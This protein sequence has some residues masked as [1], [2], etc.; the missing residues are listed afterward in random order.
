M[1]IRMC[2]IYTFA[3]IIINKKLLQLEVDTKFQ[4]M[5]NTENFPLLRYMTVRI[6]GVVKG[7][8]IVVA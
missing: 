3:N 8:I 4:P 5:I 2:D 1:N 6:T 7:K